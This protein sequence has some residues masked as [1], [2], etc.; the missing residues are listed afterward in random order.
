MRVIRVTYI[1]HASLLIEIDGVRVLTDPVLRRRFGHLRRVVDE[2]VADATGDLDAVL[3]SHAHHDHLDVPSLRALPGS[4]PVFGPEPVA[5][6]VRKAGLQPRVL[7][8]GATAEFGS[9]AVEVTDAE[10]DG[11]RWPLPGR[12]RDAFG[13]VLR[14]GGG[15]GSVYFAGD[16]GLNAGFSSIG[17]V[18][19]ALLPVAGWGPKLGPGHMGPDEAAEVARIIDPDVAIPIHWGTYERLMMKVDDRHAPAREFAEH[20]AELAPRT[21]VE[22][23]QP[24]EA[25]ELAR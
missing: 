18:T 23:L 19:V 17:P 6:P 11:R 24:G 20:V 3:V 5:G 12:N 1:G 16:T 7:A 14:G 22:I 8:H 2:P 4:P 21:R 25:F 15:E 13:F 9:V 10:H